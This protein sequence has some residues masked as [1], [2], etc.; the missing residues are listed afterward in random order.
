VLEFVFESRKRLVSKFQGFKVSKFQGFKVPKF[1]G[2]KVPKF[3]GFK[4]SRFQG[5]KVSKFQGFKVSKFQ[6]FKVSKFQSFKVSKFQ[7]F[8]VSGSF[9]L[10]NLSETRFGICSGR[11]GL[12]EFFTSCF[13]LRNNF[14]HDWNDIWVSIFGGFWF[15][16]KLF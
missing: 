10:A 3:Q 1:Q 6:G 11:P 4:V 14:T 9:I 15:N 7:G 5:F 2:F 16:G 8:K 12:L 13:V